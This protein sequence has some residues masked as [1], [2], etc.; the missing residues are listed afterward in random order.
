MI[1]LEF[2]HRPSSVANKTT[3]LHLNMPLYER[4][5]NQLVNEVY[6]LLDGGCTIKSPYGELKMSKESRYIDLWMQGKEHKDFYPRGK[7][8]TLDKRRIKEAIQEFIKPFISEGV[9][10]LDKLHFYRNQDA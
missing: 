1:K 4:D 10:E 3:V 8:T 5:V 2:S 7:Q 9:V 6:E